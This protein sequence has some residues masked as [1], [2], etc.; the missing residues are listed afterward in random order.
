[1]DHKALRPALETSPSWTPGL[2]TPQEGPTLLGSLDFFPG[3]TGLEGYTGFHTKALIWDIFM[4]NGE[5]P[6]Q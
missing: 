1:M 6:S 3:K 2:G 4:L 5:Q